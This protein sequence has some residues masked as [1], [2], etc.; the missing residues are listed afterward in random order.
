M[1]NYEDVYGYD[2]VGNFLSVAHQAGPGGWT[3]AYAYAEPSLL[4]RARSITA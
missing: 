1:R 2:E 4:K 3:R